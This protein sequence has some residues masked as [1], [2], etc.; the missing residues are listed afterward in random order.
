MVSSSNN[1][2]KIGQ[3]GYELWSDIP[4]INRVNYYIY[5]DRRCPNK[6]GNSVMKPFICSGNE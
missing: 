6:H 4:K 3:G 2:K 5:I 1:Y